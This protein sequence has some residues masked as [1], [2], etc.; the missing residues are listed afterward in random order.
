MFSAIS[1]LTVSLFTTAPARG[2]EPQPAVY[3]AV[4]AAHAPTARSDRARLLRSPWRSSIEPLFSPSERA[5]LRELG[6]ADLGLTLRVRSKSDRERLALSRWIRVHAKSFHLEGDP[7]VRATDDSLR[8]RQW[9]LSNQ[10]G[11]Y[12]VDIDDFT[13]TTLPAVAGE[14]IGLVNAPPAPKSVIVA[15]LDSG[16]DIN[17][18]DLADAIVRNQPECAALEAY[19]ACVAK[20]GKVKCDPQFLADHDGNGYPLDCQGWNLAAHGIADPGSNLP[21]PRTGA[22][23]GDTDVTDDVG[24]GTH[25]AGIIAARGIG[26]A[27]VAPNVKILPVRVLTGEPSEAIRVQDAGGGAPDPQEDTLRA[28]TGLGDVVARGILYAVRSHAQVINMS[29][30]W[31]DPFDSQL[32]RRMIALARAQGVLLVAAAGNDST[33]GVILPCRYDGV[34]CVGAHGPDGALTFFSNYGYGVDVLAPGWNILSTFPQA[35][36]PVQFTG[37]NG[38][39]SKDGTSMA[40]PFVSGLLANLLGAG[41]APDEAYARMILGARKTRDSQVEDPALFAESSIAGNADIAGA[42]RVGAQALVLPAHKEPIRV[43]WDRGAAKIPLQFELVD[44]WLDAEGVEIR[45]EPRSPAVRLDPA[46]WSVPTWRSRETKSFAAEFTILDPALDSDVDFDVHVSGRNLGARTFRVRANVVVPVRKS[47]ASARQ[48]SLRLPGGAIASRAYDDVRTVVTEDDSVH[49]YLGVS[50]RDGKRALD[51]L[52]EEK[53]AM[54]IRASST[55]AADARLDSL[56]KIHD[57]AS[58]RPLYALLESPAPASGKA[59]GA[60]LTVLDE[61]LHALSA[62][63]TVDPDVTHLSE[64]FQWQRY[65]GRLAP[66][67][68]SAGKTPLLERKPYDPWKP[69]ES[70]AKDF[71]VYVLAADGLRSIALPKDYPTFVSL[72]PQTAK[73][74]KEGTVSALVA[75]GDD[76]A[77]DYGLVQLREGSWSDVHPVTLPVFHNLHGLIASQILPL[78]AGTDFAGASFSGYVDTD[79]GPHGSRRSTLIGTQGMADVT[80]APSRRFD[81]VTDVTGSFAGAGRIAEFSLTKFDVQYTDFTQNRSARASQKRFSFLPTIFTLKSFFPLVGVE[82]KQRVP[83]LFVPGD[84]VFSKAT[85]LFLPRYDASGQLSGIARPAALHLESG[86]GCEALATARAADTSGPAE[87][88]FFCGDHFTSIPVSL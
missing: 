55:G 53:G 80:A 78:D 58:G 18:P 40:A 81:V 16:V 2:A 21:P 41:I 45:V 5:S 25:V 9:G 79:A 88:L 60:R 61:S 27:G 77:L 6:D 83:G 48:L 68:Y 22:L 82:G 46:S 86:P 33:D 49:E 51:L 74:K 31:P 7:R 29:L 50:E 72:L 75:K 26:V 11:T 64:D 54:V 63:Q 42:A 34:I 13:R 32:V 52:A 37:R 23:L 47:G 10:G 8:S 76:Y 3:L 24:H 19:R 43:E 66:T 84:F 20:N 12:S 69:K 57:P 28:G 15:V 38:Y 85:Q 65:Q 56:R 35:L 30:G 62:P 4:P 39:E 67:W 17:H 1:L 36:M 73:Q 71:R 87:L 14:D 59:S 44:H 70:D